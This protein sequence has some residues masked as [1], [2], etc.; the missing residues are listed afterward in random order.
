M[1]QNGGQ[2]LKMAVMA[3]K[4]LGLAHEGQ[5]WIQHKWRNWLWVTGETLERKWK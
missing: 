1:S 2:S 5:L 4:P 3:I